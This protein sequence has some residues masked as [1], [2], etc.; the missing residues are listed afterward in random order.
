V[1]NIFLFIGRYFNFL[2]FLVLQVVALSMLVR[3]NKFHEALFMN[4]ASGITGRLNEKYNGVE[5]YFQLKNTNEQLVREN[6]RLH[7]LIRDNY[8][9]PDSNKRLFSF[10]ID[11]DSS[12]RQIQKWL[13]MEAKIVN[14][15]T[16]AQMNFLTI[17]RGSAQGVQG[18]SG[19]VSPQG[20]VGEVINVSKNYSLIMSV[21]NTQFKS[22]VKLK[23]SGDRGTIEW[24]GASPFF[25]ILKDIPKSAIVN[26]GDTIVTSEISQRFPPNIT[27][28]TVYE[29]IDDKS[30][31]F[32]TLRIR[33][34]TNF[35][36]VEYVYVTTNAQIG[37][38]KNLEDSSIKKIQ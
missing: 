13:Y 17:H 25:V 27:V 34:S 5:Y 20:I 6:E 26:K 11:I 29:I 23:N 15:T 24:D 12:H 14:T 38:Q 3:F 4:F 37:E 21:L 28:G 10:K 7:Q 19:V 16:T 36:N 8:E 32:Y 33:L 1:R 31:N 2:F 35:S 30:T 22:V 9:A 18:H